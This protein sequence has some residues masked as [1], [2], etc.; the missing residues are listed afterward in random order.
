MKWSLNL[1]RIAGIKI[2]IHWTFLILLLWIVFSQIQ[3][4]KSWE[5]TT[6]A[7]LFIIL[8][9][10]CVILHELG[11]AL[12]ARRF[13]ISTRDITL[14][15]IGGLARLEKIPEDPKQELWV[16]LAGPAV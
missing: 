5:Q 15:P 6:A 14:L 11:H 2:F 10:G 7:A 1:G 3:Q 12:M 8:I 9:F 16:A 4:G 13:K